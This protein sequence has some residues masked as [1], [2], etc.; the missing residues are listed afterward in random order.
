MRGD[1]PRNNQ[2]FEEPVPLAPMS[3]DPALEVAVLPHEGVDEEEA[4]SATTKIN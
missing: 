3:C 4:L 1:A 2:T